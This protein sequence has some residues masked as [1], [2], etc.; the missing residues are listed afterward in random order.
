MFCRCRVARQK[1]GVCQTIL[2]DSI[3]E[4]L[5]DMLLP[6]QIVK[7]LRPIFSR[8]NFVAHAR[9]LTRHYVNQKQKVLS[10]AQRAVGLGVGPVAARCSH[11]R[12]LSKSVVTPRPLR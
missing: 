6:D 8:E 11:S 2:R 10:A 7:S 1:I 4:R 3:L 12:A 5:G 9:N